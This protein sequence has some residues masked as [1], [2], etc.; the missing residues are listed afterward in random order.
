ML[1]LALTVLTAVRRRR[2][3]LALLK[4]FGMT[5]RQIRAIVAWQ[6]STTLVIA[7]AVGVPVGIAAGNWAWTSFGS[8]LGVVHV[9]VVSGLGLG[10]AALLATGNLLAVIPAAVA[11]NTP[12]ADTLRAE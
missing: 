5:R 9:T 3:E 8:S 7:T 4:T 6:T 2:R 12:P 11:A 10:I 1:S